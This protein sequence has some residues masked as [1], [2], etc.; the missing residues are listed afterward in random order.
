MVGVTLYMQAPLPFQ[1]NEFASEQMAQATEHHEHRQV[2]ARSRV[3]QSLFT[4]L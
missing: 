1:G 2:L 3:M 4:D